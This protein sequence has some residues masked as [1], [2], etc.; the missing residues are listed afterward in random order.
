MLQLFAQCGSVVQRTDVQGI[1]LVSAK[2][3][4]VVGRQRRQVE[5]RSWLWVADTV[6]VACPRTDS[7][8][9]LG[10]GDEI[11]YTRC[12]AF[13]LMRGLNARLISSTKIVYL[14]KPRQKRIYDGFSSRFLIL[15]SWLTPSP[16]VPPGDAWNAERKS[17]SLYLCLS[18]GALWHS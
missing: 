5:R 6:G 13:K 15:F 2:C 16:G 9:L 3:S 4:D 8:Q 10:D 11:H 18:A 12:V 14:K 17:A 1:P 7:I